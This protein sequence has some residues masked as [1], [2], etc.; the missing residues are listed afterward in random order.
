[1]LINEFIFL[2]LAKKTAQINLWSIYFYLFYKKIK[3]VLEK[4]MVY[5]HITPIDLFFW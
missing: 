4:F 3:N 1:M 5:I 2:N